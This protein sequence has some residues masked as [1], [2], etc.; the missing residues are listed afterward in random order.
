MA[1]MGLA[2][3]KRHK[4]GAKVVTIDGVRFASTKEGKRYAELKLLARAGE[5]NGLELQPRFPFHLNGELMFTYVADFAYYERGGK[6]II[7]DTKGFRT[8][9]FKLKK[10]IIETSFGITITEV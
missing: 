9:I 4:Y 1:R 6:R 10:K 8:P 7:E 3:N 5:I 2:I